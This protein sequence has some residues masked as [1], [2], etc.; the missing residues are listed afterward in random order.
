VKQA[1]A[2]AAT[3][4]KK[5]IRVCDSA[6]HIG[7]TGA[8]SKLAMKGL[9]HQPAR[10]ETATVIMRVALGDG[11]WVTTVFETTIWGT[12]RPAGTAL[13]ELSLSPTA[14]R[15]RVN[16][17]VLHSVY[18]PVPIFLAQDNQAA[19]FLAGRGYACSLDVKRLNH[20]YRDV[21][22]DEPQFLDGMTP[23]VVVEWAAR[24]MQPS[25]HF[26]EIVATLDPASARI[27]EDCII[28]TFVVGHRCGWLMTVPSRFEAIG[29][30]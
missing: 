15:Y 14:Y 18:L 1:A 4:F 17:G 30:Q 5:E 28:W 7:C 24:R 9:N 6:I 10:S 11:T 22:P 19:R 21:W 13:S 8:E 16:P 26:G 27:N 2:G 25:D 23:R 29:Q 12:Q 3:G 20:C